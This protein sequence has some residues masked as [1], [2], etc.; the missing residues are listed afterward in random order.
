MFPQASGYTPTFPQGG[1]FPVF[2]PQPSHPP[3][4]APG[5][6]PQ[7]CGTQP[8]CAPMPPGMGHAP[9]HTPQLSIHRQRF[10]NMVK[11]F[12]NWNVCYFCGFGVE[13]GH[14]NMSGPAHL[15]KASHDIHFTRQNV[16]QYINLD[17]PCCTKNKHRTTL[18]SMWQL[19]AVNRNK[20]S[21]GNSTFF[22][23]SATSSYPTNLNNAED[24]DATI[25]TSNT[26][27]TRNNVDF[28]GTTFTLK[29]KAVIAD[30][31]QLKSSSW[32]VHL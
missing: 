11:R 14:T 4:M 18:P 19:G 15:C 13:N 22:V 23:N 24:D 2:M 8:F 10:S 29:M 26:L 30:S 16:Q 5:P 3:R 1:C 32:K 20:T 25:I 27:Y 21:N 9:F 12:A 6:T 28:A 31:G 17:H 7:G